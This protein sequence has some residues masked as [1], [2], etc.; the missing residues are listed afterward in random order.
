MRRQ[1]C[2]HDIPTASI[3]DSM[4]ST[5]QAIVPSESRSSQPWS[6]NNHPASDH[7]AADSEAAITSA[8][9]SGGQA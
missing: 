8:A 7:G 4:V 9:Y 1:M 6:T 5:I 2:D 3:S